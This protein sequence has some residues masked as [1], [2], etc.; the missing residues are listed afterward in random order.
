MVIDEGQAIVQVT[1]CTATGEGPIYYQWEKYNPSNNSWIRPSHRVVNV[2]SP[3]L[4]FNIITEDDEGIY[5]CI[6]SNDDGS[7]ASDNVTITVYGK[8]CVCFLY[9]LYI[10]TM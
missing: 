7:V 4:I 10:K 6:V 9:I 5:H 2:N 8:I 1:S 3:K